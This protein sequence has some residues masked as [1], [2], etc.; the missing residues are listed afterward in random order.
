MECD[1]AFEEQSREGWFITVLAPLVIARI[2]RMQV[3][4]L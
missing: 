2:M 1:Y 3:L 4:H